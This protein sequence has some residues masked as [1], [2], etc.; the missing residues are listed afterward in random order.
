MVINKV[1]GRSWGKGYEIRVWFSKPQRGTQQLIELNYLLSH[2]NLLCGGRVT[3]NADCCVSTPLLEKGE[4]IGPFSNVLNRLW[5]KRWW[6]GFEAVIILTHWKAG[7]I[8][9]GGRNVFDLCVLG[10]IQSKSIFSCVLGVSISPVNSY[11]MNLFIL[12]TYFTLVN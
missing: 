11:L 9:E 4:V 6:K 7:F 8:S 3:C 2:W 1:K 5:G 12:K 10:S